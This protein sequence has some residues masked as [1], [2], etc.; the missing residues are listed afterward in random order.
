M[1]LPVIENLDIIKVTDDILLIHQKKAQG[2]FTICDGL[3]VL[4][5]EGRNSSTIVLDLNIGQKYV[6]EINEIYGPVSSYVCTHGHM[7]HIAHVHAWEEVGAKIYAPFPEANTLSKLYNFFKSFGFDG[8]LNFS[9]LEKFG[10]LNEYHPC[11]Q[12][13]EFYPG[14]KLKFEHL[15]IRTI[16]FRGHSKAHIGFLLPKERILHISCLGFDLAKPGKNGFGPWYGF[17]ECSIPEYIKDIDLAESIFLEDA[18]FLTSSH[19]YIVIKSDSSPFEYMRGKIEKNQKRVDDALKLI[20]SN[21]KSEDDIVGEL[22]KMDLFFPKSKME[23]FILKIFTFW[24]S[25]IIRKHIE[26]SNAL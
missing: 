3:L 24:E 1:S 26:R 15:E 17:K 16:P 14:E 20:N 9:I 11:S 7:D 23:G 2:I 6:N 10:K 18:N 19:S 13:H 12:V 5:K 21:L 8:S 25:W 4:P 22:L